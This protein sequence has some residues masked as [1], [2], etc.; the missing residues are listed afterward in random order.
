[1]VRSSTTDVGLDTSKSSIQ[2]AMLLPGADKAAE[3][4]LM[5][6][7][8]AVRLLAKRL[9]REAVGD[10]RVCYEA[11]PCGYALQR[12]L[13]EMDVNAIVVAPSLIPVKP[14]ERVK[15]NRRD[16]AKL[17][18]MLRA[19]ALTE[20]H[21]PTLEEESVRD[22]CRCRDDIRQDIMRAR[23]RL[24]K[25]LLRRGMI[26]P[27]KAWTQAHRRWLRGLAFEHEAARSAF[28]DYMRAI[29]HLEERLRAVESAIE[30]TSE[31]EPYREPVAWLRC[32]RGIDT[33]TAMSVVAELHDFGRF[34]AARELMSYLGLV[35]SEN[36]TGDRQRRGPITKT[37]NKHA[38][39]LLIEASWHYRH[40]PGVGRKLRE[41]RQGQPGWVIALADR[42]HS[43][44]RVRELAHHL[45][46][47]LAFRRIRSLRSDTH[48]PPGRFDSPSARGR[49]RRA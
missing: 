3:W 36:S 34:Q 25:M 48:S 47:R 11:G 9:K 18:V 21:P 20:V 33:M 1:M 26:Y 8:R 42:A 24:G 38:R 45:E 19:G 37:G 6:E 30:A 27:G 29:E 49:D 46:S 13:R 14:G 35:P 44:R 43:S 39:R 2:V 31:R 40:K 5:N 32:F 41:R 17:A 16:A 4:E 23:H 12:Q 15:T 28:D 7:P 22:L 10:L